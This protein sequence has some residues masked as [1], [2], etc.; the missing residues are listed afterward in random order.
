MLVSAL[1]P[2]R[3]LYC[4]ALSLP[5]RS[6]SSGRLGSGRASGN[7]FLWCPS[8]LQRGKTMNIYYFNSCVCERERETRPDDQ[9]EIYMYMYICM[10]F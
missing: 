7:S 9:C 1:C 5:K 4:T 10:Y 6:L 3:S 8:L 2:G